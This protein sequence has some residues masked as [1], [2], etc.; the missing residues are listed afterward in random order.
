MHAKN[1][2]AIQDSIATALEAQVARTLE[3]ARIRGWKFEPKYDLGITVV[4]ATPLTTKV[5][6]RI[7]DQVKEV[8]ISSATMAVDVVKISDDLTAEWL[9]AH[10]VPPAR[11][12]RATAP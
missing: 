5:R 10:A 8:T 7:D 12:R 11:K 3:V 9:A 2:K 6:A 4:E 1:V